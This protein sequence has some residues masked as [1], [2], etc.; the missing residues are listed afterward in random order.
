MIK[1]IPSRYNQECLLNIINIKYKGLYDYFYL[2]L[3]SHVILS[4]DL[5][6]FN[7]KRQTSVT[8]LSISLTLII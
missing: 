3:D 8:H 1:N 2:P 4:N 6:I 7:S 5:F